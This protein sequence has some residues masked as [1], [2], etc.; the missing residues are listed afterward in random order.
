VSQAKLSFFKLI[1]HDLEKE[2]SFYEQAFGF[3]VQDRFVTDDFNEVILR[4]EGTDVMIVLQ[5]YTDGREIP[6]A[7]AHGP[8]GFA[9]DDMD[10]THATVVAA[11][12]TPKGPVIVVEGGIKVAF[13]NDPEG[14]EIELCQFG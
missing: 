9:T 1:V 4:Q 12:A 6:D 14:H 8:A 7:R 3:T 5:C 2:Q 13:L 10:A 11:G